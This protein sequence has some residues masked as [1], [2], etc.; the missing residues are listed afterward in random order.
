MFE[1]TF[2]KIE[3]MVYRHMDNHVRDYHSI[4]LLE[5]ETCGCLLSRQSAIKGTSI[6]KQ[7]NAYEKS[8]QYMYPSIMMMED[9]IFTPYY[10][11]I[12]A[13]KIEKVS[14]VGK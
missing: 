7:R 6:I 1:S 10:C 3:Q 8:Y 11:K 9:Y 14:E 12:H 2:R 5:C 13:P 4:L